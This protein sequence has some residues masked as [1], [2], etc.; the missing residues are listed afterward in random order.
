MLD[1][2]A[3]RHRANAW[4]ADAYP[5]A[6]VNDMRLDLHVSHHLLHY[7][8]NPPAYRVI[9]GWCTVWEV[10]IQAQWPR[11]DGLSTGGVRVVNLDAV[12]GQVL[13]DHL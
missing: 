4:F 9:G 1:E 13:S 10:H 12:T 8:G 7:G 11:G 6:K 3:A 2:T 5:T